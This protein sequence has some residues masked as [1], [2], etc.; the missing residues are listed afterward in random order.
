MSL[1]TKVDPALVRAGQDTYLDSLICGHIAGESSGNGHTALSLQPDERVS[2]GC[3]CGDRMAA[4]I[5]DSWRFHEPVTIMPAAEFDAV[6]ECQT[7]FIG[8]ESDLDAQ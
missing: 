4:A 5:R 8:K 7:V 3:V 1:I 6:S 2:F